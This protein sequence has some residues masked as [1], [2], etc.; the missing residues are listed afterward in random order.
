MGNLRLGEV[1]K[2]IGSMIVRFQGF[3]FSPLGCFGVPRIGFHF[4][5]CLSG[6]LTAETNQALV[7]DHRGDSDA[8]IHIIVCV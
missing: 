7:E 8:F 1:A 2:G 6:L 3:L 5:N 4:L